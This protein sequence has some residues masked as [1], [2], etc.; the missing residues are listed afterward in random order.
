MDK[1]KIEF[2][3][4]KKILEMQ[5][6]QVSASPQIKSVGQATN[7]LQASQEA[8]AANE[9]KYQEESLKQIKELVKLTKDSAKGISDIAK[10]RQGQTAGEKI[11]DQMGSK[12]GSL[13]S[14]LDTIGVVNKGSGGFVDRALTKREDNKNFVRAE[15]QLMGST[16][17]EATQKLKA[18]QEQEKVVKAN[19]RQI[20]KYANMGVGEESLGQT[21]KGKS[22]L[23]TRAQETAKLASMD[24]RLRPKADIDTSTQGAEQQNEAMQVEQSQSNMLKKIEE[25]T[26]G[27]KGPDAKPVEGNMFGKIGENIMSAIST[28]FKPAALLKALA[29]FLA[30][31][32]IIG[33]LANGI[34]DGFKAWKETGSIK[35]AVIQGLGGVLK[36]LTFGL[37]DAESIRGIVESVTSFVD[38]YIIQPV[39]NFFKNIKDGVLNM[40]SKIGIPEIK[41]TIPVINKD[42]SIGPY[43]PFADVNKPGKQVEPAPSSAPDAVYNSSSENAAYRELP[44]SGSDN[45][46]TVV[47]APVNNTTKQ[48]NTVPTPIRNQEAS[49]N[50]YLRTRYT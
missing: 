10:T 33:S 23:S 40:I 17:G 28:L 11:R 19:E 2:S 35:E 44:M 15:M 42:V 25:N 41:F 4:F 47:N 38:E 43:Y 6:Q 16:K 50:S 14:I 21:K 24:F 26:R 18:I 7:V 3:E 48:I 8:Q 13:R 36:F 12:F 49:V 9:A 20:Q 31:V 32:M 39:G 46:T 22:L 37:F 27:G 45:S 29:K 30:P 1:P 5:R 34:M